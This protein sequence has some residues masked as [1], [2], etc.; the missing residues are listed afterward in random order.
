MRST[1]ISGIL[2]ENNTVS[3]EWLERDVKISCYLPSNVPEPSQLNLLLINDGQNM[4]ELGLES[5]LESLY[6]D[7]GIEPLFCVAIH[8]GEE[9]KMEYGIAAEKDYLGRGAKAQAYSQF[10]LQELLPFISD[11]Y[12]VTTFKE[13][14]FAGFSLGGLSALDNVWNHPDIFRKAG[15]FSGSLWWRSLDQNDMAYDDQKHRIMHQQVRKGNYVAGLKF[16][17]Q[18]GNKD[19]TRDRNNNGIIDSI[20]DTIDLVK[21]LLNKGYDQQKD[22]YY[23]EMPEGKHDIPT[24]AQAMPIFLKWAWGRKSITE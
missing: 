19:E 13:K 4:Q 11:H 3:S 7:N 1:N 2:V 18:C 20:D 10:V 21:E 24:W 9:R 16:F 8:A 22:I 15:V 17:L 23:L 6:A 14:G 5:I 12:Q